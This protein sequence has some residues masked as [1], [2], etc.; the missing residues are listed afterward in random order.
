MKAPRGRLIRWLRR[1]A[2]TLAWVISLPLV[3]A[4]ALPAQEP[5]HV[6]DSPAPR[7]PRIGLV[8]SGGGAR[9]VAHVGVL[10]VLEEHRVPI[11]AIAGTSMGAIVGGLYAAGLTPAEIETEIAALDWPALLT[12][13]LPRRYMTFRRLEEDREFLTPFELTVGGR[14][15]RLPAGMVAGRRVEARLTALLLATA[16]IRDFDRLAVPFRATGTDLETGELVVLRDG[17]LDLAIR[18]SMS[19]PAV[20]GPVELDGRVLVDG[21]VAQNLPVD[22]AREMDVDV[23]IAVDVGTPL[24]ERQEL[25]S[26]LNVTRQLTNMVVQ[27]NT[28]TQRDALA[29]SDL[30]LTP[31]LHDLGILDFHR[32]EEALAAGESSA[33]AAAH[34]LENLAV[35]EQEY[36]DLTE[37]QR[38]RFRKPVVVDAVRLL[39]AR[40]VPEAMADRLVQVRPGEV[41]DPDELEADLLRLHGLRLFDRIHTRIDSVGGSATLV[42]APGPRTV[43]PISLRFGFL[44]EDD[45]GAGAS[46]FSMLASLWLRQLNRHGGEARLDLQAGEP[47]RARIELFQ[48]F[49]ATAPLFLAAG[50]GHREGEGH[51]LPEPGAAVTYRRSDTELTLGLGLHPTRGTE[52]RAGFLRHGVT[53]DDRALEPVGLRGTGMGYTAALIVDY[54]DDAAFPRSG[55]LARLSW[56]GFRTGLGGDASY[57][58]YDAVVS[59]AIPAGSQTVILGVEAAAR[60]ADAPA[61]DAYVLGGALRLTGR[62]PGSLAGH[63]G[64]LAR[65]M[66]LHDLL[67]RQ[68]QVGLSAEAGAAW[69][70][71]EELRVRNVVPAASLIIGVRTLIGPIYGALGHAQGGSPTFYVSIGRRI[72]SPW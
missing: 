66:Y 27:A 39:P 22:V 40:G 63:R 44:L 37:A 25:T 23:L 10:K 52:L 4:G 13:R 29:D 61:Y 3:P 45:V 19:I 35:S 41:I 16:A 34:A 6:P 53:P 65:V 43:G 47:R 17:D 14:G 20:F 31:E 38:R 60:S 28:A 21:G 51:A 11:H 50:A 49:W 15:P 58:R 48:P 62:A 71:D 33:R 36:A 64:G 18:A 56:A 2:G 26:L 7:T 8:L 24:V 32:W 70:R 9:G 72:A 69:H 68:V 5:L 46:S 42:I 67:G 54:M 12:D 30:L 1:L 57:D 55:A 59:Y